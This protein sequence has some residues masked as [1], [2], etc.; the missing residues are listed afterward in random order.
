MW[1]L[2]IV[3]CGQNWGYWTLLTEMPS[4]MKSVLNFKI[5]EVNY[6]YLMN[7]IQ[8]WISGDSVSNNIYIYIYF[9]IINI[10]RAAEY[11]LYRI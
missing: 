11:P 9:D 7:L 3:H 8:D 1:A 2:I 10:Y 5:E 6:H 4:Y